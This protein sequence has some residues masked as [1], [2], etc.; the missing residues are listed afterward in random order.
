M[1]RQSPQIFIF[2]FSHYHYTQDE[3][4]HSQ[5]SSWISVR[6]KMDNAGFN[7]HETIEMDSQQTKNPAILHTNMCTTR[8]MSTEIGIKDGNRNAQHYCDVTKCCNQQ[9]NKPEG[10]WHSTKSTLLLVFLVGF[11]VWAVCYFGLFRS[12]MT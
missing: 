1:E 2:N 9:Q 5:V 4:K 10:S 8:P 11:L 6:R 3:H 7:G 12:S